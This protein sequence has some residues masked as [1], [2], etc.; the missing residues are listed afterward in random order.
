MPINLKNREDL[1]KSKSEELKK[2]IATD[3]SGNPINFHWKE[4]QAK[5]FIDFI[6]DESNGMLNKFRVI[7]MDWPT[8][9]IAK[10]LDNGKFLRPGWEYKRGRD[11]TGKDGYKF[12]P[13]MIQLVSKKVEGLVYI[14][15]DELADNI[16]GKNWE[17]HVKQMVSKKIANEIVEAAIY[18]RK[19]ATPNGDNGILNVFDGLKFSVKQSW[20][21][22]D[23]LTLTSREIARSTIIKGKK[24]LKNK[25]RPEVEVLMDSD[26]KTDLDEL[27]NDP[28]GNKGNGETIK[29][30]VSGMKLNEVP[31][32]TSEN[33]VADTTVATTTN[34]VNDAGQKVIN[35]TTD[36]TA[37]ISAGKSIVVRAW[38]ADELTYTVASITASAITTVENLIY[39][40][41][42]DSTVNL[43]T[44][45][46]ADTIITNPKNVVVGIQLDVKVEWERLA[47]DGYNIWY[48]MRTDIAVENPE[49]TVLI[50]NLKSKA[51]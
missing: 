4:D 11:G 6:K 1:N 33:A 7:S 49:A 24:V 45:D 28:N 38:E 17:T 5:E 51:L 35:V 19:L 20:N 36:K 37:S 39:D 31:L 48:T 29:T 34:W 21:V 30:T 42:A 14:S 8:K 25:Y 18:G 10:I 9:E 27:Y 23:G 3:G 44:L 32:M 16:E 2:A 47:P 40:I 13:D 12:T 50:E 43:A 46:W 41:P 22:I 26:L 15:D